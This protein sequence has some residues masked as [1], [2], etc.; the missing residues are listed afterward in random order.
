MK[1]RED[2]VAAVVGAVGGELTGKVRLQ[3]VVYLLDQLGLSSGFR[4][5]YYHYGPFSRD[6]VNAVEDAKAFNMVRE[7]FGQRSSDLAS[8][9]IF[10]M[11]A[12]VAIKPEAFGELGS[13]RAGLLAKKLA[14]RDATVLELA[15]TVHWL[16]KYEQRK[17]WQVE[18]LRRKGLKAQGGRLD[19]ALALLDELGLAPPSVTH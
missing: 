14:A 3:K 12:D 6:L 19:R 5:E 13:D 7:D 2:V 1:E 17:N 18:I 16:W 9:S 4:F 15:A 10:R 11:Q 8:F